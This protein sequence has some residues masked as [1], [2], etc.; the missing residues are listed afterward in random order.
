MRNTA[1]SYL[2]LVACGRVGFDSRPRDAASDA[3]PCTWSALS[4]PQKLP[5]VVQS[6]DDDWTPTPTRG[7]LDLY[8]YSYRPGGV[9]GADLWHAQRATLADSFAAPAPVSELDTTSNEGTP[10]LT[11]DGLVIL[12]ARTVGTSGEIFEAARASSADA[13]GPAMQ[14]AELSSGTANGD[15]FVTGDG[16]RLVFTS[17]RAG[18]LGGLDI[19]ETSRA[20]LAD[21]FAAPV[22]RVELNSS[23]DEYGPTLSSDG[24]EIFFASV[25]TGGLGGFD[26]YTARRGSVDDPFGPPQL[27]REVSSAMDDVGTRLSADGTTLYLDYDTLT[28]GGANADLWV[29]TRSCN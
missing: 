12:F 5:A 16:L 2:V 8:F 23:V 9:G 1:A 18:G 29:A 25:R 19:Y 7:G 27:V 6:T 21:A 20:S 15:P 17:A 10:T 28:S 3:A 22:A 4:A 13:F 11:A 14:V 24:L 26:V